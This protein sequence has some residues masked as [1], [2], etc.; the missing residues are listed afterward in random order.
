MTRK[1]SYRKIAAR[2][3]AAGMLYFLKCLA[4]P[5]KMQSLQDDI[6][7]YKNRKELDRVRKLKGG[8]RDARQLIANVKECGLSEVRYFTPHTLE[9]KELVRRIL[10]EGSQL[11]LMD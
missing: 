4:D 11:K 2:N 7:H 3:H 5:E 9:I 8:L 1:H 6:S 10:K